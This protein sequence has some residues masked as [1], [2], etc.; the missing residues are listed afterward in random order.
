MNS[1][2]KRNISSE[3]FD[4]SVSLGVLLAK[5]QLLV[6]IALGIII[7]IFAIS[8]MLK[9]DKYTDKT[10][11]TVVSPTSVPNCNRGLCENITVGYTD[12]QGTVRKFVFEELMSP[13]GKN[14]SDGDSITLYLDPKNPA[15]VSA[16]KSQSGVALGT[17]LLFL[18]LV[19]VGIAAF[20]YWLVNKNKAAAA[21]AGPLAMFRML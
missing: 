19:I 10:Q 6:A 17:F 7:I 1:V 9:K 18:A 13:N 2:Q 5:I 14:Y 16:V 20:V 3:L 21:F 11:G 8:L 4:S 15:D 12:P